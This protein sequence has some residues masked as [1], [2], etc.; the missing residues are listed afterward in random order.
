VVD[1]LW[2]V[3]LASL[4]G[5]FGNEVVAIYRCRIGKE[6]NSAA[7]VA[8]GYHARA[9]GLTSLAVFLGALGLWLGIPW[10]DPLIGAIIT[11][12]ILCIVWSSAKAVF[13]R[14]IDGVDPR[15]ASE[16]KMAVA[17]VA[18]VKEVTG[19]RLRWL[20]HEL[21]A[22]IDLT[23]SD[24]L[25]VKEGHEIAKEVQHQ[26]MHRLS[27]LSK[28]NLHIDPMAYSGEEH[29]HIGVHRHG[30]LPLHLHL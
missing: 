27:Y 15:A 13:C 22:E 11:G 6:I 26:L 9:D 8:D 14:L 23:V 28:A 29:H 2:A 1:H 18:G 3:A 25:S 4:I 16:V 19:V 10:A 21:H 24:E 12:T 20:G 5:F 17:H 7:L 30:N